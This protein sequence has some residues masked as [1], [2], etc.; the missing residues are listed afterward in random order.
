MILILTFILLHQRQQHLKLLH[1]IQLQF[2]CRIE[3]PI[4]LDP[5]E[6]QP[7]LFIIMLRRITLIVLYK[8]DHLIVFQQPL[9]VLCHCNVSLFISRRSRHKWLA[10]IRAFHS[11]QRPAP[12]Q[13]PV[14]LSLPLCCGGLEQV[15]GRLCR[16]LSCCG[17]RKPD[18]RASGHWAEAGISL[19]SLSPHP[20]STHTLPILTE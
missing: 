13:S 20:Y 8:R 16:P 12:C 17:E 18:G 9:L 1:P 19:T 4:V 6:I 3:F 15:C 11:A 2:S 5:I 14:S 10:A 7:T